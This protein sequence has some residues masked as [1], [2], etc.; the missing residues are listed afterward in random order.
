MSGAI[1]PLPQYAFMEW[2]S[3]KAQGQLHLHL[4]K[5][6]TVVSKRLESQLPNSAICSL[7]LFDTET[8]SMGYEPQMVSCFAFCVNSVPEY[9]PQTCM[10]TVRCQ[11][12]SAIF[13]ENSLLSVQ[14][15][16]ALCFHLSFF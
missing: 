16:E 1:H 14:N 10:V 8:L 4:Y 7:S 9:G 5:K 11:M 6:N 2:C 13:T 3:V 15:L 12:L